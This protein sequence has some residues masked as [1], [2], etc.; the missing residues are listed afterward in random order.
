MATYGIVA[1]DVPDRQRHVRRVAVDQYA[2]ATG[3]INHRVVHYLE[4]QIWLPNAR[5]NERS[6]NVAI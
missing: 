4:V 5:A 1:H 2:E 3:D 6:D